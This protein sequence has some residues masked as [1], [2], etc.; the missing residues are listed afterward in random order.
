V[1]KGIRNTKIRTM[2]DGTVRG[3]AEKLG[4][5]VTGF[6]YTLAYHDHRPVSRASWTSMG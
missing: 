5:T 3:T 4:V 1:R 2:V 6:Y